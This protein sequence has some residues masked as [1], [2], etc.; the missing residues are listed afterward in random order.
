MNSKNQD[1]LQQKFFISPT[2]KEFRKALSLRNRRLIIKHM[3]DQEDIER[4][5]LAEAE[6]Y[7]LGDT[8][9]REI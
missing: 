7:T 4:E 3:V 1:I 2:L 8:T 6:D 9:D 5:R